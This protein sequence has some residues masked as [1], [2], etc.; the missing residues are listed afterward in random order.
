[1]HIRNFLLLTSRN[2]V[3]EVPPLAVLA[4]DLLLM[5]RLIFNSEIDINIK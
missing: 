1:M 4:A 3:R 5:I 2:N